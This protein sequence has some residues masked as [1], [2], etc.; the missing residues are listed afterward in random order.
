VRCT[1]FRFE[2]SLRDYLILEY[3]EIL[4][5]NPKHEAFWR[6]TCDYLSAAGEEGRNRLRSHILHVGLGLLDPKG[7]N[8]VDGA[9]QPNGNGMEVE[10]THE[11]AAEEES[12]EQDRF[13]HF[14]DLRE[15]CVEL[16]LDD[17]WKMISRIMADKMI[18]RGEYGIAA[19]MCLQAEDGFAL[20]Q[21]ADKIVEAFVLQGET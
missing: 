1:D 9:S 21:I 10:T 4:Q 12:A 5:S 20:S 15:A 3:A 17:E 6:V 14:A 13:D 11:E 18:R 7:K 8:K 19:T 16:R 2:V